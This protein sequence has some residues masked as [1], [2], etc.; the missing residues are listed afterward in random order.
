MSLELLRH[1]LSAYGYFALFGSLVFGIV[2]LPIPDETLLTLSGYL[3]FKGQFQFVPT[4]L[5]AFS[6]SITG[7][8]LS[9]LIGRSGGLFLI[10]K[11]GQ[12][13]HITPDRLQSVN[14]WFE[15]VGKWAL[16]IGYFIPGIRHV[17]ALAAGGSNM[18]FPVFAAFAYSGGILW[19]IT[20]VSLGYYLG[21]SWAQAV[22]TKHRVIL[23][24]LAAV[25]FLVIFFL[26][27]FKSKKAEA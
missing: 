21:E 19:S 13:I 11:F 22:S 8:S 14:R 1:W 7:I 9:F 23:A 17:M 20:F 18:R 16:M 4:C 10:R 27:I 25:V 15:R 12:K 2:G 6:G 5:A 26:W 24:I 3:V